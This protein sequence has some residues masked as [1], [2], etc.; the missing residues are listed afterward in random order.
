MLDQSDGL[1]KIADL[2]QKKISSGV[3]KKHEGIHPIL[4]PKA[5]RLGM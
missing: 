1:L 4:L 5:P 3:F 2:L